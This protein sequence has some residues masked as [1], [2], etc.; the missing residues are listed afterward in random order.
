MDRFRVLHLSDLHIL[1]ERSLIGAAFCRFEW[2][3]LEDVARL[4]YDLRDRLDLVLVTGD[5]ADTGDPPE[6]LDAAAAFCTDS[7]AGPV[8]YLTRWGE[9]T[10][11]GASVPVYLLPGN[12]DRFG[13]MRDAGGRYFDQAFA[14]MWSADQG[15]QVYDVLLGSTEGQ[16]LAFIAAALTL[17]QN[18]DAQG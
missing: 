12:H 7:P 11:R 5:L 1:R 6:S 3:L 2:Y 9:P 16:K 15:A 8:P 14:R 13:W 18:S 4:V 10:L 17:R